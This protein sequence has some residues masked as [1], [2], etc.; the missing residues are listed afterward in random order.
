M[1]HVEDWARG[2]GLTEMRL[3]N[4]SLNSTAQTAWDQLGFSVNEEVR[5]K[6][7]GR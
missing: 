6:R 4:S 2:R 1:D 5:L 3:H 7:I